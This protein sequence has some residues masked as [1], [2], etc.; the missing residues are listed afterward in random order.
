MPIEIALA[1][2]AFSAPIT[3]GIV[4]VRRGNG[5]VTKR[6]FDNFC[7]EL[8]DRLSRIESSLHNLELLVRSRL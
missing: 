5:H 4:M 1:L 3:A 2:L 7:R 8:G 6:E